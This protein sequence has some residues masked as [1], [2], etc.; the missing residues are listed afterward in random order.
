MKS[1]H[2]AKTRLK[3]YLAVLRDANNNYPKGDYHICINLIMLNELGEYNMT[4]DYPELYKHKPYNKRLTDGWFE[5]NEQR[6]KAI[7]Q[8]ITEVSDKIYRNELD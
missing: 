6:I 1:K 3:H 4:I 7:K 5:T 8:A 2:D